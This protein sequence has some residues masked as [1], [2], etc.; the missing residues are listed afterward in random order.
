MQ[1]ISPAFTAEYVPENYFQLLDLKSVFLLLGSTR[2]RSW[3]RRWF[4][5]RRVGEAKSTAQFSRYRT[6]SRSRSQRISENRKR[7]S[8]QRACA[9]NRKL[10]CR[11]AS[12]SAKFHFRLLPALSRSLA[13]TASSKST[14]RHGRIPGGNSP[15]A[16]ARR[17]ICHRD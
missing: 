4:V 6:S 11:R 16:R 15:C 5:S 2:S 14:A 17:L 10:L 8:E 7:K 12:A 9:S 13:K 3:V 1:E